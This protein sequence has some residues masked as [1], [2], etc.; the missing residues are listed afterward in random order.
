[1]IAK[2]LF[3]IDDEEEEEEKK[4]CGCEGECTCG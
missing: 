1:M 2:T 4:E 3:L